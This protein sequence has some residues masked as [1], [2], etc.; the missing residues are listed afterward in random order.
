MLL[1]ACKTKKYTRI[2]CCHVGLCGCTFKSAFQNAPADRLSVRKI[3]HAAA[4]PAWMALRWFVWGNIMWPTQARAVALF[5]LFRLQALNG[6]IVMI[7]AY[8]HTHAYVYIYTHIDAYSIEFSLFRLPSC[9][10]LQLLS[11]HK[12]KDFANLR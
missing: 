6:F 4:L 9:E 7:Q 3:V 1:S 11:W 10:I 12:M 5:F 8:T 2:C